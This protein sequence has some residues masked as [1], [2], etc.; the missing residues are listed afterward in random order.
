M[1]LIGKAEDW[2]D[3]HHTET[4]CSGW[5]ISLCLRH[6]QDDVLIDVEE[7]D[8]EHG[9]DSQCA[10]ILEEVQPLGVAHGQDE[11]EGRDGDREAPVDV[12]D[13]LRQ[14]GDKDPVVLIPDNDEECDTDT[15]A[16]EHNGCGRDLL[17]P[18]PT[19]GEEDVVIR[20]VVILI[21]A[22]NQHKHRRCQYH[23]KNQLQNSGNQ[24]SPNPIVGGRVVQDSG[25]KCCIDQEES[26]D[27]PA[28]S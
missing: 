4:S 17:A 5:R 28:N 26:S 11:D 27:L 13:T 12:P 24:N 7:D 14:V 3:G 9:K 10:R 20:A 15:I 2:D 19:H 21:R 1:A 23:H 16:G 22:V 6:F 18:L 8:I 25:S